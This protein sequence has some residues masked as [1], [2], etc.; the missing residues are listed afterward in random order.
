MNSEKIPGKDD[1]C[2]CDGIEDQDNNGGD[3]CVSK[4]DNK[5]WCYVKEKVCSDGRQSN[6]L[7]S[8]DWSFIACLGHAPE[9]DED[10]DGQSLFFFDIVRRVFVESAKSIKMII[11]HLDAFKDLKTIA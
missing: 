6:T 9:D 10:G 8:H 11:V 1:N 4:F 2:E 5:A 7:K 3:D